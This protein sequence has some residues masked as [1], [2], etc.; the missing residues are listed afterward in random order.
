MSAAFF[1]PVKSSLF[2]FDFGG[3]DFCLGLPEED[4]VARVEYEEEPWEEKM[5]ADKPEEDKLEKEKS[6]EGRPEE[7]KLEKDVASTTA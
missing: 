6:E 5:E 7:D 4:T 1:F 3:I 2:F